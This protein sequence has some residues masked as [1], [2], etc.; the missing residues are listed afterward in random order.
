MILAFYSVYFGIGVAFC[1]LLFVGIVLLVFFKSRTVKDRHRNVLGLCLIIAGLL[2]GPYYVVDGIVSTQTNHTLVF[3]T[4]R[5][6]DEH[7]GF[8][9]P[10][11]ESYYS[12]SSGVTYTDQE[13][14]SEPAYNLHEKYSCTVEMHDV[15]EGNQLQNCTTP[16]APYPWVRN[17]IGWSIILLAIVGITLYV[18]WRGRRSEVRT[19]SM[20]H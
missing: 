3:T 1:V 12:T 10:T 18:R 13:S 11:Y 9:S 2:W 14:T 15:F 6:V 16:G 8:R 4:V 20:T 19:P 5:V 7:T 17:I